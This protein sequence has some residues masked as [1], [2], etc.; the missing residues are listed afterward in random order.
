MEKESKMEKYADIQALV[1]KEIETQFPKLYDQY[2]GKYAKAQTP[3]HRHNGSDSPV[4]QP[5]AVNGFNPLP[6]VESGILASENIT[7][8]RQYYFNA[9]DFATSAI[10]PAN[11]NGGTPV[12]PAFPLVIISGDVGEEELPFL[13]GNAP[14]GTA[15]VYKLGSS[16]QLWVMIFGVW[17]GV[18]L[19]VTP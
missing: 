1:K 2:A 15:I 16:A 17:Y 11:F 14:E 3:L 6:G 12:V 18:N 10:L 9:G 4:L 13:G 19:S 7:G 5:T 8:G